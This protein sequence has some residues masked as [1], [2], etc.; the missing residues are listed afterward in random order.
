MLKYLYI[1]VTWLFNLMLVAGVF[2]L[3]KK[4]PDAIRPYKVW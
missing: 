1:F 3:R 4:M 2:I